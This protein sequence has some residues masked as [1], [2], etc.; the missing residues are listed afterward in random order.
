M[1]VYLESGKRINTAF[2]EN[3]EYT[4][5]KTAYTISRTFQ[6]NQQSSS[7]AKRSAGACEVLAEAKPPAR[8]PALFIDGGQRLV[9]GSEERSGF[10]EDDGDGNIAEKAFEFPCVLEGVKKGAVV[11]FLKDFDVDAGVDVNTAA[12]QHFQQQISRFRTVDVGPKIQG[13]GTD[14]AG[15]V[16]TAPRDLRGRIGVGIFKRS[17]GNFR[18]EKFVSGA[19]A[20]ARENEFPTYLRIAAAHE[21]Q[22][23]DLLLGVR[24]EVGMPA[25]GRHNAIATAIPHQNRLAKTCTGRE[26]CPRSA[27]LGFTWIEDAEIFRRK[28]LDTVARGAKVI[29]ENDVRNTQLSDEGSS[30]DNPR[31]I[32]GSNAAIDHRAGNAESSGNDALLAE[33][34]GRLAREFL[35][36]AL[37]LRELLACEA[38]LEDGR[39]CA[40]FFRKERQI[41]LRPANVPCKD[42]LFPLTRPVSKFYVRCCNY[43]LY[44]CL[45]SRS[46]RR[47][48]SFG[49]QLPAAYCGTVALLAA[50]Q[51]SMMGSTSDQAASTL[52]PRSKSVASPRTQSFKS[53]A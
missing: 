48:D 26:Q 49:P 35:D 4:E 43:G 31:K 24:S 14:A 53:V 19:E 10:I 15:L 27:R 38:L 50:L 37:K 47:S 33:M 6:R 8:M 39:K 21:A 29:Q 17:M 11:H 12:R 28:M 42:Q 3:A 22:Q 13:V 30:I 46:S 9:G 2:A 7:K 41:T 44:H 52:S 16:Q 5:Q 36:D 23:F 25:F 18:R 20:A 45:P 40:A 1:W 51:T 34:I 32:R